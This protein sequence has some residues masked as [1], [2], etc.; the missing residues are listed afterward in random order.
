MD[1]K[2]DDDTI[3]LAAAGGVDGHHL[4][5]LHRLGQVGLHQSL[6]QA[7][8]GRRRQTAVLRRYLVAQRVVELQHGV[9]EAFQHQFH[10]IGERSCAEQSNCMIKFY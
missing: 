9:V 10:L 6:F 5:I 2:V 3:D 1:E 4:V 8:A 7:D